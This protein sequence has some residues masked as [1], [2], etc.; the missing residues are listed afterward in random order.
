MEGNISIIIWDVKSFQYGDF[1][2]DPDAFMD[3]RRDVPQAGFFHNVKNNLKC[4]I[5][6]C[7]AG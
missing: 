1:T 3:V 7:I 6:L 2:C 4:L 5:E